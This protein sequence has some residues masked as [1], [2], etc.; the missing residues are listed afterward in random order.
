MKTAVGLQLVLCN[1]SVT[2]AL[3]FPMP[4]L[5]QDDI[6]QLKRCLGDFDGISLKLPYRPL[7][8]VH[9]CAGPSGSYGAREKVPDGSRSLELIGPLTLESDADQLSVGGR[10]A[11]IQNAVYVHFDALFRQR[12]YQRI[13]VEHADAQFRPDPDTRRA[14]RRIA[15][16]PSEESERQ[17]RQ[18]AALPTIPYVK[19]ARYVRSVSG[20]DVVLTYQSHF[21]NT[22]LVTIDGLPSDSA[23]REGVLR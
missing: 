7:M 18:I 14:L 13:V 6:E 20:H 19:L 10:T 11:A 3:A 9:S 1:W 21:A 17:R 15:P 16:L 4:S 2:I 12:G 8:H 23:V 22:W 5:A